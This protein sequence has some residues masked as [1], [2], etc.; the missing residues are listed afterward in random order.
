MTLGE[1]LLEGKSDK[2][3]CAKAHCEPA[4][5]AFDALNDV[6]TVY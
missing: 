3:C 2:T 1:T 6:E 5:Q 4:S